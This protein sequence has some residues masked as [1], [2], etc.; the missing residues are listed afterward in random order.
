[1]SNG[2]KT[3]EQYLTDTPLIWSKNSIVIRGVKKL[4]TECSSIKSL[5]MAAIVGLVW[6]QKMDSMAGV[7]G[8]LGLV[9]AKE[10][11]FSQVVNIIQSRFGGGPKNETIG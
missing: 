8:L 7:V 1:M 5:A 9:G 3:Q 10:I 2:E 6:F 11:D 4:V